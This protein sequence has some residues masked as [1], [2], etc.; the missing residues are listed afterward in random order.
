[1]LRLDSIGGDELSLNETTEATA[2][3]SSSSDVRLAALDSGSGYFAPAESDV[4]TAIVPDADATEIQLHDSAFMLRADYTPSGADLLIEGADGVTVIIQGYYDLTTPPDLVAPNGNRLEADLVAKLAGPRAPGEFAQSGDQSGDPA[5]GAA[6]IGEIKTLTGS[7][8]VQRTDGTT[9]TVAIGDPVFQND[10]IMTGADAAVGV[11]FADGTVFNLE[12]ETRMVLDELVYVPDGGDGNS[13]LVSLIEGAFSFVSGQVTPEGDMQ[14]RTPVATLGIRGTWGGVSFAAVTTLLSIFNFA[15]PATGEVHEIALYGDGGELIGAS[16]DVETVMQY[17]GDLGIFNETALT[18]E[19]A[20]FAQRLLSALQQVVTAAGADGPQ[21]TGA[22]PQGDLTRP[23]DSPNSDPINDGGPDNDEGGTG[24]EEGDEEQDGAGLQGGL[25]PFVTAINAPNTD[26]DVTVVS[27]DITSVTINLLEG[28][29]D[30]EGLALTIG[31][32]NVVV[33]DVRTAPPNLEVQFTPG[34]FNEFFAQ[35]D[36]NYFDYLA[37]GEQAVIVIAYNVI[38][39]DGFAIPNTATIVVEGRN[40]VPVIVSTEFGGDGEEPETAIQNPPAPFDDLTAAGTIAFT[41]VDL[42]DNGHVGAIEGVEITGGSAG[43]FDVVNDPTL[44]SLLSLVTT[45]PTNTGTAG[46]VDWSFLAAESLFDYLQGSGANVELTYTISVTDEHGASTETTVVIT[47]DGANDAPVFASG[48]TGAVA[49]IAETA[50]GGDP[51]GSAGTLTATGILNFTDIDVADTGHSSDVLSVEITGGT[52]G[53]YATVDDATLLALLGTV[54]T[55][56]TVSATDGTTAWNFSADETV[57]DYLAD[58]ESAELTFTVQIA[59]PSGATDETTVV[60]TVAGANDGPFVTSAAQGATLT[61]TAGTTGSATPLTADG[62]ITFTDVDLSESGHTASV[63][64][65]ATAG[66]VAGLPDAATLAGFFTLDPVSSAAGTANGSVGW[67]FSAPDGAFDYLPAG[68]IV[69]LTLTVTIEDGSGAQD[70]QDIDIQITGTNDAPVATPITD[71]Y[72]D[73][74]VPVGVD[75]LTAA[76]A[77]DPDLGDGIAVDPASLPAS[78]TTDD[79]RVLVLGTHFTVIGNVAT[80]TDAG[81][82]AFADLGVGETDSGVLNYSVT[83]GDIATP[84]TLTLTI[85]GTND[86]IIVTPGTPATT[87][88]G[89]AVNFLNQFDVDDID[90]DSVSVTLEAGKGTINLASLTGVTVTSGANGTA[91]LTIVG[92]LAAV[93]A[94]LADVTYTPG[95]GETGADLITVTADDQDGSVVTALTDIFILEAGGP[96][97][98]VGTEGPDV[99]GGTAGSDLIIGLGDDDEISGLAGDDEISAGS[100]NDDASGG[101]GNDTVAGDEGEDFLQGNAGDDVLIGGGGEDFLMPGAGNDTV[102]GGEVGVANDGV[103]DFVSYRYGI[104]Q[105]LIS[106]L[107]VDLEAGTATFDHDGQSFTDTLVGIERAMGTSGAD[108][109]IGS[110]TAAFNHLRGREGDDNITTSGPSNYIVGG[111][112]ND[113]FTLGTGFDMFGYDTEE[114]DAVREGVTPQGITI[115]LGA[116]TATDVFGDTDTFTANGPGEIGGDGVE[117]TSLADTISGGSGDNLLVG[118]GGND[119]LTG[120]AGADKFRYDFDVGAPGIDLITDFTLSEGDVIELRNFFEGTPPAAV[121]DTNKNDFVRGVRDGADINV[122]V[123][124]DGAGTD[125]GFE[126]IATLSDHAGLAD[127]INVVF[128]DTGSTVNVTVPT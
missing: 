112:G 118:N 91:M 32:P 16:S 1:M 86:A 115:D 3:S 4:V 104:D 77:F 37:I 71:T 35:F 63:A 99:L 122:E 24:D 56:P 68:D 85:I 76:G 72:V 59:D 97:P 40:D 41:D 117:G 5:L 28:Q 19:L 36:P 54:T 7:V 127:Q 93:K 120:E 39:N 8:Q 29:F 49:D 13:L 55:P 98:I 60:V 46:T 83:D 109:L 105:G 74:D 114:N 57:F 30:P 52:A 9:E 50:A 123:D 20:A 70:S 75:L 61:E 101:D 65:V 84:N 96:T 25:P 102:H 124:R 6:P 64:A 111:E 44:L 15:D 66:T 18:P 113:V 12:S 90:S 87:D 17:L 31:A 11:V 42:S 103:R 82:A 73:G 110:S 51:A 38:D 108:T 33:T 22:D 23:F 92:L 69:T 121:D 10:V 80:L 94:A 47:I 27:E 128:E 62:L 34:G 106:N 53:P 58:G 45:A 95:A 116:G 14:M 119:T 125:F 48:D 78:V 107:I 81:V 88:E 21:D 67:H 2:P 126:Q 100:G 89:V 43:A 26:E 79:G